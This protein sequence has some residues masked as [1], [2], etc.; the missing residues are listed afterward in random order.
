VIWY[1][2][3]GDYALVVGND[4]AFRLLAEG[5]WIGKGRESHREWTRKHL[6]LGVGTNWLAMAGW[7]A[8]LVTLK[9]DG[10]LWWWDLSVEA[11]G[12]FWLERSHAHVL[13]VLQ[14]AQPVRMGLHTDW[15]AITS[16]DHGLIALAS[17][18]GLWYWRLPDEKE[19]ENRD[20][21][22]LEPS[23]KPQFL[24]NVFATGGAS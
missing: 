15:I 19:N 3:G 21:T 7:G 22:L 2:Y 11:P 9:Q 24:G 12:R 23:R 17:D 16:T 4:G 5:Q 20:P 6:Q 1:G 13:E 8:N 10:S 14:R 18:G